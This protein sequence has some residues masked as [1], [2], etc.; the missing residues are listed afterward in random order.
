MAWRTAVTSS[1]P[2]WLV[3]ATRLWS[4]PTPTK[5]YVEMSYGMGRDGYPAISMTQYAARK[6]TQWLSARTGRF[7][8]LPTEAEWEYACRAGAQTA[9]HFGDDSKQL[10]EYAWHEGN[11]DFKY[12][13]V[14]TKKPNPWGLYDMHGNVAEW[15]LDQY[16]SD[17]YSKFADAVGVNPLNRPVEVYPRVVRGGSWDD[18]P[19]QLRASARRASDPDWKI[20]DP[21]IPRS[22]W[23]HTDAPF[24]GLRVVRP[25]KLPSL[26]EMT[27]Y[28][29]GGKH[30]DMPEE[31]RVPKE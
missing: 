7:Y 1:I 10:G 3:V 19:D 20:Q 27:R 16:A 30:L 26:E 25:V 8:R 15:C 12:Q 13:K 2:T 17:Y 23:L 22:S 28:W 31:Y 6:Y 24:L 5:P 21:Q 9:Y 18:T 14:G 29:T 11:S 4:S